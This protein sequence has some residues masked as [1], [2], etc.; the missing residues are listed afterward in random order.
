MA[1]NYIELTEENYFNALE[2]GLKPMN[3]IKSQ[4]TK[5]SDMF[6]DGRV[7]T[8]DGQF[9]DFRREHNAITEG[10]AKVD[11]LEKLSIMQYPESEKL[12]DNQEFVQNVS[13][14]IEFLVGKDVLTFKQGESYLYELLNVDEV[15]LEKER[16]HMLES[17]QK[18]SA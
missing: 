10:F 11:T 8:Y 9:L 1:R 13:E 14:F 5:G 17:L 2:L 18:L 15:A 4:A 16:K 6:S 12:T 7:M 3:W